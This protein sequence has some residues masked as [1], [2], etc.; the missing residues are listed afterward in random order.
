MATLGTPFAASRSRSKRSVS[1]S[2]TVTGSVGVLLDLTASTA[3]GVLPDSG[4]PN[5]SPRLRRTNA[6]ASEA[7]CSATERS[8]AV[9]LSVLLAELVTH[10]SQHIF[11][12]A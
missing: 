9:V 3:P 7:S 5:T 12:A 4:V 11:P 6:A 8:S 2:T 1:V 10:L